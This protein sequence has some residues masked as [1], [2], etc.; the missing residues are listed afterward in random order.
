MIRYMQV[1]QSRIK[2]L[3]RVPRLN[4]KQYAEEYHQV[5][6]SSL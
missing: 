6:K 1:K 4:Y 5:R 2:D 3:P